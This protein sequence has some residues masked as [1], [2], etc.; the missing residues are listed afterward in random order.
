M[1]GIIYHLAQVAVEK[2]DEADKAVPRNPAECRYWQQ[3]VV[4]LYDDGSCCRSWRRPRPVPKMGKRAQKKT[5]NEM[6]PVSS[7]L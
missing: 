3:M 1:D 6:P 2:R 4:M 7:R 5:M